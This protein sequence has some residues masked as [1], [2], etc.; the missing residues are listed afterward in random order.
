MPS[1]H[2]WAVEATRNASAVMR[3]EFASLR[4]Q[5]QQQQQPTPL[6]L[7]RL[8]FFVSTQLVNVDVTRH[9]L[10]DCDFGPIRPMLAGANASDSGSGSGSGSDNDSD[11]GIAGGIDAIGPAVYVRTTSAPVFPFCRCRCSEEECGA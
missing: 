2:C 8:Q 10:E 7:P 3:G 4:Q 6:A 1:R 11:G 5:Q 9:I